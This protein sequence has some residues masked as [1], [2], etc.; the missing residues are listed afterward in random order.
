M[1]EI[2]RIATDP[3]GVATLTLNRPDKHNALSEDL[4]AALTRAAADLSGDHTVR[5]VVLTG[6]GGSFC[7]GGDLGWM[8]AQFDADRPTR[9]IQARAL[10]HML[11]E[12]N[13][14]PKP[15]I[16][17]VNGTA[18]GGGLGLMAVC[19]IAVVADTGRFGFTETRLGLIPA[20]IAPY[21]L[22][23]MGEGRVRQVFMSGGTFAAE[24]LVSLGLAAQVVPEADLNAAVETALAPYLKA[25][26][27]AVAASKALA[28]RLGPRI[29][30]A[31]IEETISA[32]ADTW[33]GAEAQAGVGAFFA[34]S[35][36]PWG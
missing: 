1:S 23:R 26:P 34:K 22:A 25:A 4:I 20:T 19:D 10:A 27:H 13:T 36:P 15:L 21:V 32:L 14:L 17:R 31:L 3:R 2:L 6:A 18:M 24:R 7:A 29:D 11:R 16:G 35:P 28:R 33:E 8:R 30:D 12:L 5:A 9:M